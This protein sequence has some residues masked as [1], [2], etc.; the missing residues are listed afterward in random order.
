VLLKSLFGPAALDI[1]LDA[2]VDQN[3]SELIS[4][5]FYVELVLRA[6]CVLEG[7]VIVVE[8]EVE[9]GEQVGDERS[10]GKA[11]IVIECL[12]E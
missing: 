7:L 8:V 4:G 12:S 3:F 5:C 1:L 11:L 9:F 10:V 2:F 6:K